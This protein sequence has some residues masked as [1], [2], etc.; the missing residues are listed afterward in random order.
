MRSFLDDVAD[1]GNSSQQSDGTS[2]DYSFLFL[3][4]VSNTDAI[5]QTAEQ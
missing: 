2:N 1:D 5:Y 3:R 4:D